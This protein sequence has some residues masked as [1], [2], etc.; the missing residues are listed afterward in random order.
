[1]YVFVYV[2]GSC[3]DIRRAGVLLLHAYLQFRLKLNIQTKHEDMV[4]GWNL[5]SFLN[6][7]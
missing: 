3:K 5:F 6:K 4:R 7:F 2:D 1:M